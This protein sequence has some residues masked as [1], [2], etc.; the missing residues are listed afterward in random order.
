MLFRKKRFYKEKLLSKNFILLFFLVLSSNCY[1]SIYYCFEQWLE[2]I[3]VSPNWRGFL[4]GSL[5]GMVLFTRPIASVFLLRYSKL[6]AITISILIA[7]ATMLTYRYLPVHSPY[8]VWMVLGLRLTQGFFLAIFSSCTVAV[9]VNCFPPGQSARGFALFSLTTLLPYALIPSGGELLLPIIGSE[10]ELYALVSLLAIP[11]L[12]MTV[13]LAP[14]LRSPEITTNHENNAEQNITSIMHSVLHSGLSLVFLSVLLFGLTT[15]TAIFFMKGL[16]RLTGGNPADFFLFYTSTIMVLRLLANN[17]MDSLPRYR[18]VPVCALLMGAGLAIIA[19][20]PYWAYIPAT[21]LYG[22]S[23]SLLYPLLAAA[24][25]DRSTQA[26]RTIN[27]N[28]MMLMF[29]AAGLCAPILGGFVIQQ[30]L[31]Y[32]GVITLASCL[33]VTCGLCFLADRIRIAKN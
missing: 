31:S 25:C 27:S 19:W 12:I 4:L 8:F 3:A 6:P 29:D 7:S 9:M 17:R 2:R 1:L 11:A 30:G 21:I 16:C 24:I 33:I 32:R 28:F 13:L 15:N 14:L 20:G 22:A 26:A 10:P 5:F 18:V 23:L